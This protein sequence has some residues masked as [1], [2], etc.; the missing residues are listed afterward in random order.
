MK[1]RYSANLGWLFKEHPFEA[2]CAAAAR[3][4]FKGVEFGQVYE[5]PVASWKSWLRDNDLEMALFN[6]PA[7]DWAK[8]ER[9][10]ACDPSRKTEF[11]DGIARAMEYAIALGCKRVNCLSG[12]A[13]DTEV[14]W[15]ALAENLNEAATAF[16]REN[17]LLLIEAINRNEMPGFFINTSA[18]AMR[19]IELAA[20]PN[21]KFQYDIYHMQ[22]SEGELV[23]TIQR[24]QPMIGHMQLADN[25]GRHQPGTGEINFDFLLKQVASL[26]YD[27]WMGCEYAP[28]GK[29]EDSLGWMI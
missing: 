17:V 19:A 16:A 13:A 26:G 11:R 7:G 15:A 27:G 2:R 25:P 12:I 8:G 20:H 1:L 18:R 21:I 14:H 4:G 24:L 29:T 22:R 3:A 28:T 6:M 10:I 23:A 5:Q 9:G